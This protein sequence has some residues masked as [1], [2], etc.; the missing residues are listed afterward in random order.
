MSSAKPRTLRIE[1]GKLRSNV[2][3]HH[4]ASKEA[5]PTP[6]PRS[7]L[8]LIAV[9]LAIAGCRAAAPMPSPQQP[10]PLGSA[11]S[12]G[13]E[14]W[15]SLFDGASVS[16]LRAYAVID[17]PDGLPSGRWE[18]ADGTLRTIPGTGTDLI[19]DASF[20][21]FELEFRWAV[22][23]GGNSGVMI[24]VHESTEPAW[25]TGPEYQILDDAGHRDGQYPLTTAG[26]NYGLYAATRG[27]VSPAGEWNSTRI[28]AK[29][30][31][32]EHW[33]NGEKVVEYDLGTAQMDAALAAMFA[34][35]VG[36]HALLDWLGTDTSAPIGIMA[37]WPFSGAYYESD[38]H[39]FMAVSRRY[40]LEEFWSYNARVLAR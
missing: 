34:M 24:A 3:T 11:P 38:A 40:W 26:S 30:A 22:S 37:L 12:P 7:T 5:S 18:I 4:V 31:H 6:M 19:T 35:A 2:S 23:P 20:E 21:D 14:G 16:G 8:L 15:I 27:V 13:D 1:D 33:L 32:V 17:G 36:S 9:L 29:G 39:V 28:V 25:T 10:S